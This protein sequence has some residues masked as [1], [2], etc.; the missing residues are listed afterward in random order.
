MEQRLQKFQI[1]PTIT[2]KPPRESSGLEDVNE[3]DSV[4]NDTPSVKQEV[5]QETGKPKSHGAGDNS[6]ASTR[7]GS[8]SVNASKLSTAGTSN[9]ATGIGETPS[10]NTANVTEQPCPSYFHWCSHHQT[11]MLQL[12]CIIQTL[13]IKCPAAFVQVRSFTGRGSS[14]KD[15]V[16]A[17][18]PLSLLPLKLAELPM[19]RALNTDLQKKVRQL[20]SNVVVFLNQAYGLFILYCT[21]RVCV[22]VDTSSGSS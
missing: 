17:N 19:P 8:S 18:T 16:K 9:V 10:I 1:M 11:V 14:V 6:S 22:S 13:A 12:S 15:R 2:T 20:H 3:D 21:V 5:K 7:R 4:F